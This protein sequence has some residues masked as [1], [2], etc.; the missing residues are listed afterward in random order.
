MLNVKAGSCCW[1]FTRNSREF[2]EE[3]LRFQQMI[4]EPILSLN[5][6]IPLG[7]L[8]QPP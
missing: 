3:Y 4:Y 6:T 2:A 7:E 5:F 8:H 1:L